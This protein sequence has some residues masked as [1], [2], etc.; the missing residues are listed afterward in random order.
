MKVIFLRD[1]SQK[2]KRGEV[3]EVA[4][5]YARNYLLPKGM[6]VIA[7]P[8]T[9]KT[10]EEQA[11]ANVHRHV[12]EGEEIY[13]L[14]KMVEGKELRFKAKSGGK[15]RIHGSITSAHIADELSKI[16]GQ[17]IDKKKILLK[18]PLRQLGT[19]EVVIA[20]SK[21][22]EAKINVIIEEENNSDV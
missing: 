20:F 5:G 6:A 16:V 2:G 21:D 17:N 1:V 11:K 3:K 13:E 14:V 22:R 12:K 10:Y 7:T 9:L 8:S 19:S 18:E 4:D 15:E